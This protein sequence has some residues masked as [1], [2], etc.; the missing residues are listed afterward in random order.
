[1]GGR[2]RSRIGSPGAGPPGRRAPGRRAPGRR[3]TWPL[4]RDDRTL[5]RD[6]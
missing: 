5:R 4:P 3:A 1:M 2:L 6:L